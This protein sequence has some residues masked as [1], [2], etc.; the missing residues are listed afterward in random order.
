MR[1]QFEARFPPSDGVRWCEERQ[2]YVGVYNIIDKVIEYQAKW[3]GWQARQ[4]EVD[5]LAEMVGRLRE[6]VLGL[7]QSVMSESQTSMDQTVNDFLPDA[8][9]ETPSEALR[10]IRAEAVE[11]AINSSDP[12]CEAHD[13]ILSKM[14]DYAQKLRSGEIE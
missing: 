2:M 7:S 4:A 11:A 9:K 8:Y 13:R 14:E 6:A 3:E 1:E 10:H 5:E 12:E